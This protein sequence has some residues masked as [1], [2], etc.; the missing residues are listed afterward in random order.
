MFHRD[1]VDRP[2]ASAKSGKQVFK[3]LLDLKSWIRISLN[4][5]RDACPNLGG[6]RIISLG[7]S[8]TGHFVFEHDRRGIEVDIVEQVARIAPDK[9][10]FQ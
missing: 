1:W 10:Y 5:W 4:K 6:H 9:P 7:E 3:P 8:L 2:A